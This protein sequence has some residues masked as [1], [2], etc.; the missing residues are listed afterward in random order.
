MKQVFGVLVLLATSVFSIAA[1]ARGLSCFRV[2][3]FL[4]T[5]APERIGLEMNGKPSEGQV[6]AKGRTYHYMI[7][8]DGKNAAAETDFFGTIF[9]AQYKCEVDKRLFSRE[10]GQNLRPNVEVER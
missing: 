4:D 2:N 9:A 5:D 6:V 3:T 7:L 10:D 1:E 8:P